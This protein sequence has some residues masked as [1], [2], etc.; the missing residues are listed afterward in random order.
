MSSQI[1][2]TLATAA[3]SIAAMAVILSQCRKP[4][5][6]PGRLFISIMNV[7]H[8]A[9]TRWGLSHVAIEKHFAI[10]DVGCGGGKTIERLADLASAGTVCGVDYSAT[11]VAMARQMNA[12]GITAGRVAIQQ[13]SVSQLPFPD[14]T[15]DLV[16]AVETHYYWP[17]PVD[18]MREIV[19]VLKPGGRMVLIAE[20]YKDERFG[21]LLTLPM[22]VL[23]ARYLTIREHRELF[24]AAGFVDVAV[25]EARGRGWICG[26]AQKPA[27]NWSR[28]L[29]G[30]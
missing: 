23:R 11:S 18:D 6:W 12:A 10:L 20:T 28:C 2:R 9:V 5:W 16:S 4:R 30:N 8:A 7:R 25:H 24:T 22:K 15:F 21:R 14:D 19:R 13:A 29:H 17:H 27:E 3:L 1:I 26:V